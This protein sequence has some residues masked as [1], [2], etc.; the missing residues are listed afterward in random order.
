MTLIFKGG[1]REKS[2]KFILSECR[3]PHGIAL[4]AKLRKGR[5]DGSFFEGIFLLTA[6]KDVCEGKEESGGGGGRT[7]EGCSSL[8]GGKGHSKWKGTTEGRKEGRGNRRRREMKKNRS[9]WNQL[10]TSEVLFLTHVSKNSK[11]ERRKERM[12]PQSRV[13]SARSPLQFPLLSMPPLSLSLSLR[14]I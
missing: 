14:Q 9:R 12:Q 7:D 1:D 11:N 3:A 8:E 4:I 10:E 6:G 5:K 2:S 13:S